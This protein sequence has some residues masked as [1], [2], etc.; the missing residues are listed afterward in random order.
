[1]AAAVDADVVIM[2]AAVADYRPQSVAENKIKKETQGDR[3][4]LELVRNPDILRQLSE[5]R[6]DGQIIIGFAA[7]TE[8]NREKLLETGRAKVVRK[9]A[10]FLVLNTVGW[11]EGFATETNSIIVIN[12]A[13]D[14]VSE[15]TGSKSS[16][17]ARILDLLS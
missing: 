5:A 12:T 17:A 14:I 3:L 9:G 8:T 13:G 4:T 1:M 10:D 15:A 2:A 16:V 7:E 11:T 6:R